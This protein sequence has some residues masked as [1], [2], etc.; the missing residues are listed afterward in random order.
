MDVLYAARWIGQAWKLVL[1]ALLC[2]T[3]VTAVLV[4][5]WLLRLMQRET[6]ARWFARSHL[7]RHG[8]PAFA[9]GVAYSRRA[10]RRRAA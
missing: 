3:P 5:G 2:L 8:F 9:A 1:G 7:A 6:Q 4:L 10:R